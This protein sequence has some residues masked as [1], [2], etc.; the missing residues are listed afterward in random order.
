MLL[1]GH[2]LVELGRSERQDRFK[3]K[4]NRDLNFR[5]LSNQPRPITF[6]TM[7]PFTGKIDNQREMDDAIPHTIISGIRLD[8]SSPAFHPHLLIALNTTLPT[9]LKRHPPSSSPCAIHVDIALP[10]SLF[11]DRDELRDA[12]LDLDWSVTPSTIDIERAVRPGEPLS[13]LS[14][15]VPPDR[16]NLDIPLHAR[17][18]QP[19]EAGYVVVPLFKGGQSGDIRGAWWCANGGESA[20]VYIA[21]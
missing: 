19:N 17:Y 10:D 3:I 16:G 21:Q 8:S 7:W 20:S 18:Q 1:R 14:L 6:D 13:H 4:I 15:N 11:L 5:T 2:G 12:L 9:S